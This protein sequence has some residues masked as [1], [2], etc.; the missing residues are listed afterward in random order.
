[1]KLASRISALLQRLGPSCGVPNTRVGFLASRSR[2]HPTSE[3]PGASPP[4]APVQPACC[5]SLS[6]KNC[7]GPRPSG[8]GLFAPGQ[9]SMRLSVDGRPAIR[10]G[11]DFSI[12][13]AARLLVCRLRIIRGGQ[14]GIV[15]APSPWQIHSG[16]N[17]FRH[18]KGTAS[19]RSGELASGGARTTSWRAPSRGRPPIALRP[20]LEWSETRANCSPRMSCFRTI[21]IEC[22]MR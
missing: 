22:T 10:D 11:W 13:A 3:D 20:K 17:R 5:N 19:R 14:G 4:R 1:M 7:S 6:F 15:F 9:G 16:R 2:F 18:Q 12:G 8:D 21:P